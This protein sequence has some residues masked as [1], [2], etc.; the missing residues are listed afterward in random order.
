MVNAV[1]GKLKIERGIHNG[2]LIYDFDFSG[3]RWNIL[4]LEE[5]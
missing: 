4:L 2:K 1:A 5:R 3:N